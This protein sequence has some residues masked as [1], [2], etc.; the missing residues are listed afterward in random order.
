MDKVVVKLYVPF[1]EEAYDVKI[2]LFLTVGEIIPLLTK[3]IATLS[4]GRFYVK[5]NEILCVKEKNILL[6]ELDKHK[7]GTMNS[8]YTKRNKHID[9]LEN[10][11][12]AV[13]KIIRKLKCLS[14]ECK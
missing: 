6:N 2:P 8:I 11:K 13:S 14:Q 3:S 7:K 4:D 10:F 9:Q 5:G 1:I 12:K